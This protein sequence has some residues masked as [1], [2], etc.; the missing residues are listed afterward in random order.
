VNF[1]AGQTRANNAIFA[2]GTIGG[3]TIHAGLGSGNVE[4][5]LD[6]TGYF[7]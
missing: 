1:H 2:L 5:I 6:V 3:V 4:A 7:Q